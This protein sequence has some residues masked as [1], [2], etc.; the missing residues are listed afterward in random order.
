MTKSQVIKKIEKL[1][2]GYAIIENV[3]TAPNQ[4]RLS[5]EFQGSIENETLPAD[6][7]GSAFGSQYPTINPILETLAQRADSYWEWENPA[8][9]S[10]Y[11]QET[12]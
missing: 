4:I 12:I 5:C 7:Y 11:L 3:D 8:V 1:G 6:Y 10:L 9:I 2:W